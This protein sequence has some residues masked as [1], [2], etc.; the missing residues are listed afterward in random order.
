[1]NQRMRGAGIR[2]INMKSSVMGVVMLACAP[3]FCNLLTA[4]DTSALS[5]LRPVRGIV[6]PVVSVLS[7][8]QSPQP[9]LEPTHQPTAPLRTTS[10]ALPALSSD[11]ANPG[12]RPSAA[13]PSPQ[14]RTSPYPVIDSSAP[15]NQAF[16][17]LTLVD[18]RLPRPDQSPRTAVLVAAVPT[19]TPT[20]A[21]FAGWLQSTPQGWQLFGVLW[22]WWLLAVA[23]A[24]GVVRYGYAKRLP[25][26]SVVR[27]DTV[28]P[29]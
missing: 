24:Y 3:V 8:K 5:P 16:T 2:A 1:M 9:L 6:A 27:Y 22:Y 4:P 19:T 29:K 7:D 23:A 13:A 10:V 20:R 18:A 15:P 28:G 17:P 14:S 12:T 26:Q 25:W 21:T 11:K